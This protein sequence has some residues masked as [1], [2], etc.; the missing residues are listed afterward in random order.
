MDDYFFVSN[1]DEEWIQSSVKMLQVAFEELTLERRDVINILG[2]T[3]QMDREKG[4]A[5]ISQKRLYTGNL[6]YE[7][8][9][10][11]LLEN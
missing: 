7:K 4:R 2:M 5:I 1:R 10:S 11:V 3:V 9:G 8:E 6:L